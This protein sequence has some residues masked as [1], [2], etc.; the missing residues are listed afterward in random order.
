MRALDS[1]ESRQAREFTARLAIHAQAMGMAP[2]RKFLRIDH[3]PDGRGALAFHAHF[4]GLGL[5]SPFVEIARKGRAIDHDFQNIWIGRAR[6]PGDADGYRLG[7]GIIHHREPL[8]GNVEME[9][10][11]AKVGAGLN[12]AAGWA[13]LDD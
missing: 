2:M 6:V 11:M 13:G 4:R 9:A 3:G 12:P 10:I 7:G 1:V 5:L 8:R